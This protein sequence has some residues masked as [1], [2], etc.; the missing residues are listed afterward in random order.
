M[1]AKGA[2]KIV[3]TEPSGEAHEYSVPFGARLEV[4][5]G[6]RVEPG[7]KLT[8]GS[9]NPHDILRIGGSV[10]VQQYI[11]R[12]VQDVYRSQG[13]E[14]NDKHIEVVVRQM[15]RKVRVEN[16]GDTDLLQGG[17]HLQVRRY[18]C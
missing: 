9:L 18:Q 1:E 17:R 16:P 15:M 12:E 4:R 10:A 11:V 13:V 2:R 6:D 14:I 7:D 5:D 8:E 3:I